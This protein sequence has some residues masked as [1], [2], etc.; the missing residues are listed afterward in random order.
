MVGD[1]DS[2]VGSVNEEPRHTSSHVAEIS[3]TP[4]AKLE[5]ERSLES[6]AG[7][8]SDVPVSGGRPSLPRLA[9]DAD[10]QFLV[11]RLVLT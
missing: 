1:T 6:E 4:P 11:V 5:P 3:A 2:T 8:P 7:V 9:G 10:A